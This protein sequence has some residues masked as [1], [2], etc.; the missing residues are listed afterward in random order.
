[1]KF[2]ALKKH[3]QAGELRPCYLVTGEDAYLRRLAFSM[4]TALAGGAPEW[5]VSVFARDYSAQTLYEAL[6]ALPVMGG[7]RVVAARDCAFD[8]KPLERFFDAPPPDAVLIFEG[9]ATPNFTPYIKAGAV[10]PVDC[11]RLSKPHVLSFILRALTERGGAVTTDAAER[12]IEAT[13]G[14]LTRID[15]ETKKLADYKDGAQITVKDVE[16]LVA[17]DLEYKIYELGDALAAKAGARS[18]RL[19]RALFESNTP[20]VQIL[21]YLYR[22]F[23]RLLFVKINP[24]SDTLAQDLGVAEY[25]V[26][27]SLR[28]TKGLSAKKLKSI[29][30]GLHQADFGFKSGKINDRTALLTL[31]GQALGV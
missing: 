9:E 21:G 17:F 11:A 8:L 29:L 31:V 22:H 28:Q 3:I 12:L 25:A 18:G 14:F 4:L 2:E 1:M 15:L 24:G 5:N 7:R 27:M 23:R 10:E 13:G 20:P 26:K 6:C 30:D 19:L 16:E